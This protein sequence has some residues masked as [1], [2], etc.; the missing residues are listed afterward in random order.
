MLSTRHPAPS[1]CQAVSSLEATL[2][3]TRLQALACGEA[4]WVE[5]VRV[6]RWLCVF[7]EGTHRIAW[8]R[9]VS[10]RGVFPKGEPGFGAH[11]RESVAPCR[12][13]EKKR[14][15]HSSVRVE[16][17]HGRDGGKRSITTVPA[18]HV[19]QH[20]LES[21]FAMM[22]GGHP[23]DGSAPCHGR[24]SGHPPFAGGGFRFP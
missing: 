2:A 18:Q 13:G 9:Q 23:G 1:R 11:C 12:L 3:E 16:L 6:K 17:A 8:N 20:G 5:C 19:Q 22:C 15:Q 4:Q 7:Q 10:V 14:A 24:Q 21:V